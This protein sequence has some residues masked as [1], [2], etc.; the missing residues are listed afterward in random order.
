MAPAP[1]GHAGGERRQGT[2]TPAGRAQGACSALALLR[3]PMFLEGGAPRSHSAPGPVSS[4]AGPAPSCHAGEVRVSHAPPRPQLLICEMGLCPVLRWS[5]GPRQTETELRSSWAG[6][7]RARRLG[8]G[9]EEEALGE[10]GPGAQGG[11]GAPPRT[12]LPVSQP[13]SLS[14][15]FSISLSPS[16]PPRLSLCLSL[17]HLSLPSPLSPSPSLPF[18]LCLSLSLSL[19]LPLSLPLS[20]SV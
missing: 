4:A 11:R 18:S 5:E 17:P 2:K 3:F 13:P 7:R 14:A 9:A 20:L 19:S 1:H 12:E 16:P 15:S 6:G 10:R 8:W